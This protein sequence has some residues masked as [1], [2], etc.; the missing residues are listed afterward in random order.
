MRIAL[1][2]VGQ[3]GK[4]VLRDLKSLGCEGLVVWC[5]EDSANAYNFFHSAGGRDI[6]EGMED[7]GEKHL[8]KL[9]TILDPLVVTDLATMV[10]SP[11]GYPEAVPGHDVAGEPRGG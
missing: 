9:D 5:L 7:F 10:W 6:A 1:I 3:W 2:G 8:K 11:H 4:Y